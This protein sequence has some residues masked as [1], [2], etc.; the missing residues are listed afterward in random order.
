MP[1][2]SGQV[3]A[4]TPKYHA[5]SVMPSMPKSNHIVV[6]LQ[7][8]VLRRAVQLHGGKNWRQVADYFEGRTDVQCLH[9]W[10]KVLNPNLVKGPWTQEVRIVYPVQ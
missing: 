4:G 7:D 5:S 6:V 9:R 3:A 10:S 1:G 2:S 8:E